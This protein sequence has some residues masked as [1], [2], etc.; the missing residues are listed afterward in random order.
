MV[1]VKSRH[2]I[3]RMTPATI[4]RSQRYIEPWVF[5][6]KEGTML[7]GVEKAFFDALAAVDEAED[8]RAALTKAGTHTPPRASPATRCSMRAACW[9]R[10]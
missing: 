4:N 2:T 6:P 10:G 8:R 7:A 1:A 3:R 9:R 5:E